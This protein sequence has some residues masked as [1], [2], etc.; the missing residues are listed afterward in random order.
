M[1]ADLQGG[2]R[3]KR[4]YAKPLVVYFHMVVAGNPE[5]EG[6]P[7]VE[8]KIVIKFPDVPA[9]GGKD[10]VVVFARA[11][12]AVRLDLSLPVFQSGADPPLLK[13][14]SEEIVCYGGIRLNLV[15]GESILHHE[16]RRSDLRDDGSVPE[17]LS[18]GPYRCIISSGEIRQGVKLEAYGNTGFSLVLLRISGRSDQGEEDGE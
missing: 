9:A 6:Y 8:I 2:F 15:V 7:W 18:P 3:C 17:V 4:G 12:L 11:D 14:R 13:F 5:V 1:P 10:Q 16:G